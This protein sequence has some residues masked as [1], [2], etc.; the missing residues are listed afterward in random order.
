MK[1]IIALMNDKRN[2]VVHGGKVPQPPD[3]IRDSQAIVSFSSLA[4]SHS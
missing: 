2:K 3:L 1:G 4:F